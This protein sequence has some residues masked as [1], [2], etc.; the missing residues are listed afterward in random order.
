MESPQRPH[1]S[2]LWVFSLSLRV[3]P[4][5]SPPAPISHLGTKLLIHGFSVFDL[6]VI[7]HTKRGL[8]KSA[9]STE[10]HPRKIARK[11][12]AQDVVKAADTTTME[13]LLT[14]LLEDIKGIN[15]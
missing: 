5:L 4:E 1:S 11:S 9:P 15:F 3:L 13:E 14:Q 10:L 6:R 8:D 2:S 7:S 12:L